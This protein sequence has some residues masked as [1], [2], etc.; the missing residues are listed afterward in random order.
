MKTK[1]SLKPVTLTFTLTRTYV[2]DENTFADWDIIPTQRAFETQCIDDF[3]D[4]AD[5]SLGS[6]ETKSLEKTYQDPIEISVEIE[7]E[8]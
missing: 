2:P 7:D 1:I 5:L 6:Y 4:E 8:E 3:Y